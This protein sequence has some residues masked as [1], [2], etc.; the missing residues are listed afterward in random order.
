[1]VPGHHSGEDKSDSGTGSLSME[2]VTSASSLWSYMGFS[3]WSGG[4][5]LL[6]HASRSW[7][8]GVGM[9]RQD[10]QTDDTSQII[11]MAE[12]HS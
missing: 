2:A 1:M 4:A 11:K 7:V 9:E 10:T 12:T 5:A 3:G 6:Q 8:P